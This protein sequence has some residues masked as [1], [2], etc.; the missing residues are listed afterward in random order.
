MA[1]IIRDSGTNPGGGQMSDETLRMWMS[2]LS[3]RIEQMGKSINHEFREI[4]KTLHNPD[5]CRERMSKIEKCLNDK[6]KTASKR[7]WEFFKELLKSTL[8]VAGSVLVS[9]ILLRFGLG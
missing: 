8:T 6:N 2:D 7:R 3:E 4:R 1:R 9:W 5:E